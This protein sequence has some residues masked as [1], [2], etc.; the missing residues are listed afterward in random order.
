MHFP[1]LNT[2]LSSPLPPATYRNMQ[3]QNELTV[4]MNLA[5]LV[6]M[7]NIGAVLR[8]SKQKHSQYLLI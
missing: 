8:L 4:V 3:T 2:Q 5:R 6:Y 1:V 7:N